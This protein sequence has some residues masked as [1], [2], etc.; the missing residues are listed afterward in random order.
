MGFSWRRCKPRF[1]PVAVGLGWVEGEEARFGRC[2]RGV[3]GRKNGQITENGQIPEVGVCREI[4]WEESFMPLSS[5]A[6]SVRD[7]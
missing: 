1:G 3:A 2:A 4:V 7:E 5:R 6:E